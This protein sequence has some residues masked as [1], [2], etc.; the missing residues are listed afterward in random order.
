MFEGQQL[1]NLYDLLEEYK[2]TLSS[3]CEIETI[4]TSSSTMTEQVNIILVH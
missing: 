4:S 3:N 2:S 1:E